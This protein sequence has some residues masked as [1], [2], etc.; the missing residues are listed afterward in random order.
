MSRQ[1]LPRQNAPTGS[2]P[3]RGDSFFQWLRENQLDDVLTFCGDRHWQYHSIHPLGVEEFSVG[4]LNDE[5]A[6]A[7][8]KPGG[9]HT[10]DP[11]GLIRQP[12]LYPK[13]TGGFLHVTV[14]EESGAPR[15]RLRFH[16]DEGTSAY[17]VIKHPT[18]HPE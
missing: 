8:E 5:N 12:F 13:P 15:L 2:K 16:D 7:G 10:T 14:S 9:K 4:A 11:D 18:G 1:I 3:S 17:Q 6:I